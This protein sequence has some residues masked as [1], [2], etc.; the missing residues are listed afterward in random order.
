MEEI[1]KAMQRIWINIAT[2][3]FKKN[4]RKKVFAKRYFS[5][6]TKIGTKEKNWMGKRKAKK[7]P[8]IEWKLEKLIWFVEKNRTHA[9]PHTTVNRGLLWL[10]KHRISFVS[11]LTFVFFTFNFLFYFLL[12]LLFFVT[13][14]FSLLTFLYFFLK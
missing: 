8:E 9:M 11:P 13:F 10:R 4:T 14:D 6:V 12:P 2:H 5:N 3:V 7:E 1:V